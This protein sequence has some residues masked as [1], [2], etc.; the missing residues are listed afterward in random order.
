MFCLNSLCLFLYLGL[1]AASTW[2]V[3][4]KGMFH[5]NITEAIMDKEVSQC[6]VKG[7]PWENNTLIEEADSF[8]SSCNRE[9]MIK[10][11]A[12][13]EILRHQGDD[14]YEWM[15]KSKAPN[16]LER[17]TWSESPGITAAET[18]EARIA[19]FFNEVSG[20]VVL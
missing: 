2:G 14:K 1:Q 3:D 7:L 17:T 12:K 18:F 11:W 9:E 10:R 13:D 5:R 8:I 20:N 15:E 19:A 6:L 16:P 4:M